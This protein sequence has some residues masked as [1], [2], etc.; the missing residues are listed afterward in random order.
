MKRK[1]ISFLSTIHPVFVW[2]MLMVAVPW[3][4]IGF[5]RNRDTHLNMIQVGTILDQ[6]QYTLIS[7][8]IPLAAYLVTVARAIKE[9]LTALN[10]RKR[11]PSIAKSASEI[12]NTA[13]QG[14]SLFENKLSAETKSGVIETLQKIGEAGAE[15][16][17]AAEAEIKVDTENVTDHQN[18][19]ACITQ[20]EMMVVWVG[21]I[22]T[23]RIVLRPLISDQ[24]TILN[25]SWVNTVDVYII[26]SF[27]VVVVFLATLH[28]L[29]WG[30][31]ET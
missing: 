9:R 2:A 18:D 4:L 27:A 1:A 7:L 19:L 30:K 24:R 22:T 11:F 3:L 8:L 10:S 20:G 26:L 28:G 12:T 23:A 5:M 29:H 21:L 6:F 14:V 17:K 25:A 16:K 31:K 13:S 15:I